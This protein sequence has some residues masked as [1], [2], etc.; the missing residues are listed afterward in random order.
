MINIKEA[1]EMRNEIIA[2]I[3]AYNALAEVYRLEKI[4]IFEESE[5]RQKEEEEQ[6]QLTKEELTEIF[7]CKRFS[8]SA[9]FV[10]FCEGL[11]GKR[12]T[13]DTYMIGTNIVYRILSS[14]YVS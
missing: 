14:V 9:S 4:K 13:A 1:T 11:G 12:I 2:N 8:T 10:E 7:K 5:L 3:K 6:H